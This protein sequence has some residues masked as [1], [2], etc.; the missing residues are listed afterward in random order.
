VTIDWGDGA[1]PS[2]PDITPGRVRW[3][4][5]RKAFQVLGSHKYRYGKTGLYTLKVTVHHTGIM[6]D[7]V[8]TLPVRVKKVVKKK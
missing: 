4:A 5:R 7:L 2:K 6:P 3:D 8:I 1:D